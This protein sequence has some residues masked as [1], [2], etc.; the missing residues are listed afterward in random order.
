MPRRSNYS[1]WR[2]R[3]AEDGLTET[4]SESTKN[5]LYLFDDEATIVSPPALHLNTIYRSTG[6]GVAENTFGMS[7]QGLSFVLVNMQP[8]G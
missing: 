7:S 1:R 5:Y 2:N 4:S 6:A 8:L 3:G